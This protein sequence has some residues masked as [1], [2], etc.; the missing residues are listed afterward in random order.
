MTIRRTTREIDLGFGVYDSERY[1][2]DIPRVQVIK[3]SN[4]KPEDQRVYCANC[5]SR[6]D[7]KEGLE[8]HMCGQCGQFVDYK[9]KDP[10]L[11][12]NQV[13]ELKSYSQGIYTTG[14]KPIVKNI[15]LQRNAP[16]V[17]IPYPKERIQNIKVRGS[18]EDAL[19][20]DT[21]S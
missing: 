19:K 7:W 10:H 15:T 17:D 2:N 1:Q 20:I 3:A 9:L 6:M 12:D 8:M 13:D 14:N 21:E 11:K 16:E 5:K 4:P 18:L